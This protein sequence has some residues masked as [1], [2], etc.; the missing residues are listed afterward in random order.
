MNRVS[1]GGVGGLGVARG[2]W[3]LVVVAVMCGAAGFGFARVFPVAELVPVLVVAV[4]VPV[5]LAGV[6]RGLSGRGF[7]GRGLSGRESGARGRAGGGR[8]SGPALW[9]S[10]VL[11]V[12]VWAVVVSATL[13]H[14]V[15]DGLPGGPALRAVWTTLLDAPH[16]LVSTVLPAPGEPE[17]LVLPHA[18][19]WAATA[20]SAE[21]ALRT[22]APLLPAVPAVVVFG[23]ALVLGAGTPGASYPAA[24]VLA[25]AVGVGVLVRSRVALSPRTAGVGVAFVGAL[26]LVAVLLGPWLPGVGEP[27]ELRETVAA[28]DVRPLAVS[29][30][31]RVAAWLR[32]GD[33]EVFSVR[34]S[35]A[36]PGEFRLAVLD[37]YDGVVWS[38]GAGMVRTGGRVP[39]EEAGSGRAGVEEGAGPGRTEV[40]EQRVTVRSLDGVWLPAVGRAASVRVADGVALSV[41]PES[42]VLALGEGVPRGF[43]YAVRSVVP[44]YDGARL[45]DADV[46]DDPARTGLPGVDAAG[47]PLASVR[48]FREIAGRVTQGGGRPYERAVRLAEWLRASYRFDAGAAPG[49]SYRSLEFFLTEGRRGTSEQFA[50][51]FAVLGRAVGLPTRVVVGFRA[52]VRGGGGEWVV[53][54]RDVVAWA[55]VR[56]AGVGWVPFWPAPGEG[57]G[58]GGV[59]VVSPGVVEGG[60]G[61][62]GERGAGVPSGAPG[63]SSGTSGAVAGTSGAVSAGGGVSVWV[64][65]TGVGVLLVV[66][67]LA[68]AVWLPYRRRALRRGDPDPRRRVVG[69]W[70]QVVE[71]LVEVGLS[72]AG[73]RTAQ[74]VAA[75]GAAR[76]GGVAGVRLEALALLVNE[77]EYGGRVPEEGE[78]EGAWGDCAVVEGAVRG[79]VSWRGRAGWVLWGVVRGVG[80]RG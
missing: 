17:L 14:E 48:A 13:F 19:V 70:E 75:F 44:S 55:E 9:P 38:S 51:S 56:F 1:G 53:R 5:V 79:C 63:V 35:G 52:G 12:V 66:G 60:E 24:G 37:R 65:V 36:V 61:A 43:G 8:R 57:G 25:G 33:E 7:G 80:V 73:A 77:V 78:V 22:R 41:D 71:R 68:Y 10:V 74:E 26:A 23:L 39:A 47:Q 11:S 6:V 32:D 42:G 2:L 67:F 59:S 3:S 72:D 64:V 50:A 30:L 16:A 34:T 27:R 15:S 54:G 46:A 76:L 28:S 69:A 4:G 40:V 20:V 29:P 21:L 62:G 49:H 18:V 58:G 31:D 45:Q